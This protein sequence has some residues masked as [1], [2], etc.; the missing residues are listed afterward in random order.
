M[1][2]KLEGAVRM[3]CIG[4]KLGNADMAGLNKASPLP[5]GCTAWLSAP[6]GSGLSPDTNTP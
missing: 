1:E 5:A 6:G 4:G 3:S 2:L